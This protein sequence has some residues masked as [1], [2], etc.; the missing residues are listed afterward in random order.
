MRIRLIVVAIV[1]AGSFGCGSS[2]KAQQQVAPQPEWVKMRPSSATYYYGIGAVRKTMD[3]GQYQ[4]AARQNA[5]A[6]MAGEISTNISSNSVLHAFESNLN[7][8]EDFTSTIKAQTQQDLEGY[9]LVD[10]WEDLE[11]YWVFY[12]LS[13]SQYQELKERR[14]SEAVKRSFDFFTSGVSER[15]QGNIRTAFV[16]LLKSLEPIKPYFSESLPVSYNGQEIF[17]GNEIFKELSATISNLDVVPVSNTLEVKIGEGLSQGQIAFETRYETQGLVS[18]IPLQAK[19]SEKPIRNNKL[20]SDGQ[21]LAKFQIDVVRSAKTRE[22]FTTEVN[23]DD[24]LVEAGADQFVRRMVHRF[25]IPKGTIAINI[26]RPSFSIESNEI[27]LGEQQIPG[28]LETSF[29]QKAI[30]AGFVV[31]SGKAD[32][33]VRIMAV[34]SPGKDGGQFKTVSLDGQIAIVN[35]NGTK[36]YQQS[37]EGFIGRHFDYKQAADD[38][39]R[40]ARRRFENS[41]FRDIQEAVTKR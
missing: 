34:A 22:V 14:K 35:S 6:D 10:S 39:F 12:R 9:E 25:T 29:R 23:I 17:L 18:D 1:L 31:K 5:L 24:M 13:K 26:I 27:M 30:D 3:V 21:G 11:N 15:E 19:Y 37:L 20:R 16:Q 7:F 36:I 41:F 38:A 2:K 28:V 33:T 32:Y 8:R 4:Q 40:E